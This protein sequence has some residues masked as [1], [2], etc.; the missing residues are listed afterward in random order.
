MGGMVLE[1]NIADILTHVDAQNKAEAEVRASDEKRKKKGSCCSIRRS[2]RDQL[3]TPCFVFPLFLSF[4]LFFLCF[5]SPKAGCSQQ[6]RPRCSKHHLVPR[7]S[8]CVFLAWRHIEIQTNN[9]QS[10]RRARTHTQTERER[11][12]ERECVCE[13]REIK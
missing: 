12:R 9:S 7:E 13:V 5:A 10:T 2:G 8:W 3:T 6:A 4:F 1:T 11:E